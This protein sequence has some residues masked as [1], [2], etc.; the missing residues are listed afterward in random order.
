M[1]E[2]VRAIRRQTTSSMQSKHRDLYMGWL[3]RVTNEIF[4]MENA[5]FFT[6]FNLNDVWFMQKIYKK[7]N[8]SLTF[9]TLVEV[10]YTLRMVL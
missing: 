2:E 1:E 7:A 3:H 4:Q 6:F 8:V 9:S 5:N 10:Y